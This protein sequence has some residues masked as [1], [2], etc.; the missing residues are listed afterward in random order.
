MAGF[1]CFHDLGTGSNGKCI[2]VSAYRCVGVWSS[3]LTLSSLLA[4]SALPALFVLLA[5]LHAEVAKL[6]DAPDL[7]SGGA[8]LRGSSPLSGIPSNRSRPR[9]NRRSVYGPRSE[10]P[11][12]FRLLKLPPTPDGHRRGPRALAKTRPR[13]PALVLPVRPVS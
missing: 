7:G 1:N 9:K 3:A 5:L 4:L 2:G 12:G 11:L 8:I 6:A 10:L 13:Q